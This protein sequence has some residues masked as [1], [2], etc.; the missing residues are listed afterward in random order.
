MKVALVQLGDVHIKSSK[1]LILGRGKLIASAVRAHT[2]DVDGYVLLLTGDIAYSGKAEE[3][4]FARDLFTSIRFDLME[5]FP[6]ALFAVCVPG[7]HDC[8]FAI[9][10][11]ARIALM[12]HIAKRLEGLDPT[13]DTVQQL[14][15]IQENFFNF[16]SWMTNQEHPPKSRQLTQQHHL[17]ID[18]R[19]VRINCYNTAW[20]SMLREQPGQL[21]F[22]P[23]LVY[24]D[25]P[26]DLVVSVFHHPYGWMN[27]DNARAFRTA[28]EAGSDIVVTGHEHAAG[29]FTRQLI[30][31]P[32]AKHYVE[33][34]ALVGDDGPDN[35]T[36]VV[37][38]V[39][40]EASKYD[41]LEFAWYGKLYQPRVLGSHTFTRTGSETGV[42]FRNNLEFAAK[43][44]ELGT[45]IAH[46]IARQLRL[47]DIFVYPDLAHR[48]TAKPYSTDYKTVR[49]DDVLSFFKEHKRV[50]I[51]GDQESGKSAFARTLYQDIKSTTPQIPLLLNGE[52]IQGLTEKDLRRAIKEAFSEQYEAQQ[53]EEF[54]QFSRERKTLIVDDW[55]KVKYN[56]RGQSVLMAAIMRD[57]DAVVCLVNDV[58]QVEEIANR[59]PQESPFWEFDRCHVKEFGRNLRGR[60]IEKWHSFGQEFTLDRKEFNHAVAVSERKID[61]LLDKNLLPAFPVVIL[62]LLSVDQTANGTMHGGSYGYIYE[63]LLTKQLARVSSKATDIGTK[64][65][66]LSRIAYELFRRDTKELTSSE[67]HDLHNNYCEQYQIRLS[68]REILDQLIEAQILRKSGD[69][70]SFQYDYC[71]YYFVAKY[72]QENLTADPHLRGELIDVADKVNFEDYSQ[73]II[74]Y[75]YL[76]NDQSIIDHVLTNARRIYHEC[77]PSDL[78][79]DVAF[80][81][82]L[83]KNPAPPLL[84]PETEIEVN[85]Q[86][87][88]EQQDNEDRLTFVYRKWGKVA[89]QDSLE[90]LT[91]MNI[92]FRHLRILGQ[93]L[94][95]FPGVLKGTRK[96]ELAEE[97]Y[98]LGLRV[99][100][101]LLSA[102]ESN[103][104][105]LRVYLAEVIRERTAIS[106][107]QATD[108]S[109]DAADQAVLWLFTA[110]TF[111]VVKRISRSVGLED[112]EF[113]Y[114]HVRE[115]YGNLAS[116]QVI[117][118]AIRLDHFKNP[119]VNELV[120]LD[121]LLHDN[122]F[123]Y[124]VLRLLVR[125]YLYLDCHDARVMQKLGATFSIETKNPQFMANK[126]LKPPPAK[127]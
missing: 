50:L 22:P 70:F 14:T 9:Q 3:Y 124:E 64:Y 7:N 26:G 75:I 76:T 68:E 60:M 65:T 46:P 105:L 42:A 126:R 121:D 88:R 116:V 44:T 13:G 90:D 55:H 81:N 38:V 33:G 104:D 108:K 80:L 5:D 117:D 112:L 63:A 107:P 74:F 93:V 45:G 110:V 49:S 27:P 35:S 87:Y 83:I 53:F 6:G 71:Y 39:D 30:G 62:M 23:D 94:R 8:D 43:L 16:A 11:D 98:M 120:G 40:S 17:A 95:N 100:H 67:V 36:F 96:V 118:A 115:R 41:V 47:S 15:K 54:L 56:P 89:Y 57:F 59:H 127:D 92:G 58:F 20:V 25:T 19:N 4:G 31:S 122:L 32:S 2:R 10:G 99:L 52:N 123:T 101:A 113:T 82:K 109:A 24:P 61:T 51:V 29:A 69:Q 78:D 84:L 106:F 79:A 66:Y 34:G 85:R 102:A 86:D 48:P 77:G 18:G 91:K 125:D 119:P 72:F 21:V 97:C 28:V 37:I 111:G 114:K 73:I 12:E 1:D 103:L